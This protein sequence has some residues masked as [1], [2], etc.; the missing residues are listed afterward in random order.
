MLPR[1]HLAWDPWNPDK[2]EFNSTRKDV[3][4]PSVAKVLEK[5]DEERIAVGNAYGLKLMT[6]VESIIRIDNIYNDTN[7]FKEGLNLEKLGLA[8]MSKEQILAY[9]Q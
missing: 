9:V 3:F 8:G 2:G 4:S 6:F 1:R 7:Y 5:E